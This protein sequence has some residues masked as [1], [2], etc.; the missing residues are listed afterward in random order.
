MR[1][2]EIGDT[3]SIENSIGKSTVINCYFGQNLAPVGSGKPVTKGMQ[4]YE[5][6]YAKLRLVDTEGFE[7]SAGQAPK[8]RREVINRITDFSDPIHCCWFC[9]RDNE[10]KLNAKGREFLALISSCFTDGIGYH[11]VPRWTSLWNLLSSLIKI[12][13]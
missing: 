9:I 12:Q 11:T 1:L 8:V 13:C 4:I 10:E 6:D 5:K 2:S 3:R 7:M